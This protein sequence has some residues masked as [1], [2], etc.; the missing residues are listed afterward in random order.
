MQ[1]NNEEIEEEH[2]LT[3]S[4]MCNHSRGCSS[5]VLCIKSRTMPGNSGQTLEFQFPAE[6][7]SNHDQTHLAVAF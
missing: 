1:S 4:S 5:Q 2:W 3:Q 7:S 6:F